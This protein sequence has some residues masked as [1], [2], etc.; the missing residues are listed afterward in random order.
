MFTEHLQC[1]RP[2]TKSPL[3][4]SPHDHRLYYPI[5]HMKRQST[6]RLSSL[7]Q[8]TQPTSISVLQVVQPT[9]IGNPRDFQLKVFD[10]RTL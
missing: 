3:H 10:S 9:S 1:I 2:C 5:L 7:P 6:E 4:G 8:D